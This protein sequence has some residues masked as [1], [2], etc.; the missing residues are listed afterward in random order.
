MLKCLGKLW[1]PHCNGLSAVLGDR[2]TDLRFEQ[3]LHVAGGMVKSEETCVVM[4]VSTLKQIP[5]PDGCV[6]V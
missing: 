3:C 1:I 4:D 2:C 6:L 5:L